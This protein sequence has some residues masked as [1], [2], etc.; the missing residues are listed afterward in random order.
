MMNSLLKNVYKPCLWSEP[1]EPGN[2]SDEGR[3]AGWKG[4]AGRGHVQTP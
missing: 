4:D 2:I 3:A 1:D